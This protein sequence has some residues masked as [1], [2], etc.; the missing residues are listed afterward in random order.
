M[1]NVEIRAIRMHKKE[2][3]YE[4][5]KKEYFNKKLEN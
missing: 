1:N 5:E 4:E 2:M 3:T